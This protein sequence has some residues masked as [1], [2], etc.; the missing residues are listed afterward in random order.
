MS[1]QVFRDHEL[2]NGIAQELEA[3]IVKMPLLR[4]VTKTGMGQRFGQEQRVAEFIA[5]SFFQRMHGLW[6]SELGFRIYD[7]RHE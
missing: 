4:F 7:V 2:E 3:L 6:N 5:D 1:E